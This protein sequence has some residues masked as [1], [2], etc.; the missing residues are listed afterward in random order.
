MSQENENSFNKKLSKLRSLIEMIPVEA[1]VIK[2]T[3][4]ILT[5]KTLPNHKVDLNKLLEFILALGLSTPEIKTFQTASDDYWK[6]TLGLA[7]EVF[8]EYL[9]YIGGTTS[10]TNPD[11][12]INYGNTRMEAHVVFARVQSIFSS[13]YE[14]GSQIKEEIKTLYAPF[15]K[16][17]EN[18]TGLNLEKILDIC[19]KSIL[20]SKT[21]IEEVFNVMLPA[22]AIHQEF[23][24]QLDVAI[25]I[26]DALIA[27]EDA[28]HK[29]SKLQKER[30]AFYKCSQEG[31][32]IFKSELLA[33]FT[34]DEINSF[35]THFVQVRA[36]ICQDIP[37]EDINEFISAT[38]KPLIQV[39]ENSFYVSIANSLYR[40]LRYHLELLLTKDQ[41]LK[42]RFQKNKGKHL[43]DAAIKNFKAIFGDLG[44]IYP[45]VYESDDSQNEHDIVIVYQKTLF[46]IE[47]KATL[48]SDYFSGHSNNRYQKLKQQFK[49]SI[50]S[51]YDQAMCLKKLILSQIETPLYNQKGKILTTV[52]RSDFDSIECICVTKENEGALATSLNL[53]LEKDDLEDFP[54][55]I[56]LAD[57]TQL[58]ELQDD[59]EVQLTPRKFVRFLEARK[60]L[61]GKVFSVDELDYWGCYLT[62]GSFDN[63]LN[64][65]PCYLDPNFSKIFDAAWYRKELEICN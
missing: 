44:T 42:D 56:N 21:K 59:K 45:S 19:D 33:Y 47:C 63:Y 25:N 1:L 10:Q 39:D 64:N 61:H 36:E 35:K 57:L 3:T 49:R 40:S 17:F 13:S 29:M 9:N 32:R 6:D 50:Q 34:E 12:N 26:N 31:F 28:F 48:I 53:L 4:E 18:I 5:E 60:H 20:I 54:Y 51:G 46:I 16:N 41:K 8:F 22:I 62:E 11:H 24:K 23:V 38:L 15:D 43:E 14:G 7:E 37:L 65:Q 27:K 2:A 58:A 52:K 30:E 55:S